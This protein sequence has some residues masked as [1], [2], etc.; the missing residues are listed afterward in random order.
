MKLTTH[1]HPV[2]KSK[3]SGAIHPLPQYAFS[4]STGMT[5]PLPYCLYLFFRFFGYLTARFQFHSYEGRLK[6]SWT[7]LIT[8][9]RIFVEVRWRSRF[10]NTSL[11]KRCTSYNA[12]PTFRRRAADRWSLRNFLSRSSLFIVGKAQKSHGARSGLYGGCSNGV[13]P[14]HFSQAEHR[15]QFKKFRSDQR[16]A[17]RFREVGGAL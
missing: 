2:P 17:A 15:I 14:I 5:L 16:S 4:Q 9:I 10:R 3:M 12:P 8:P 1:L 11:G 13:P 6:S 7:H